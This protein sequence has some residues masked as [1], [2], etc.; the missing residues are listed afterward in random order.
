M[1]EVDMNVS[2][3]VSAKVIR[4]DGTVVDLGVISTLKP[5]KVKRGRK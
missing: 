5:K 3:T 1:P 2:G 4:A